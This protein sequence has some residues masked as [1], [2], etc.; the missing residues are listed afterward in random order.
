MIIDGIAASEAIDSSG[1]ILDV[2]G[3]DISSLENGDGLLNWEHRGEDAKGASANDNV[4]H[5]I[6]AKKIF[7][8]EDASDQR[9]RNYWNMVKLPYI[10]IKSRLYDGSGHPGAIALA[11]QIRDHVKNN[12]KILCRYSIEGSTLKKNGNRLERS[13]ARK[14]ACTVKPCNKSCV[15]GVVFDPQSDK[16]KDAS[17]SLIEG[18]L[19]RN[20]NGDIIKTFG[21]VTVAFDPIV[22]SKTL[23]AGNGS[24]PASSPL[25]REDVMKRMKGVVLATIRD[26]SKPF[27]KAEFRELL[28]SRLP[29]AD[30]SFLDRFADLAE[31]YQVKKSLAKAEPAKKPKAKKPPAVVTP[32]PAQETGPTEA[33]AATP[34][35]NLTIR[36]KEVAPNQHLSKSFFDEGTGVLHTPQGSF[37]MYI[38]SRDPDARGKESFDKIMNDPKVSAFHDKAMDNWS[39]VNGLL[40]AGQLP[41]EVVMHGTLFSQLSPNCL[42]AETE[43]LTKRGWVKGFDLTMDD[44]ILTKNPKTGMAEW[45]KPTDLRFFPDYEGPLVELK[46]RSF[47]AI[48]TPDH[49]WLVKSGRNNVQ[50]KTSVTINP[51]DLIHRTAKSRLDD[52]G[53]TPDVSHISSLYQHMAVVD[54]DGEWAAYTRKYNTKTMVT[55]SKERADAEQAFLTILGHASSITHD[56]TQFWVTK[57]RQKH[58]K[59]DKRHIRRYV[60]KVGMWCPVV[61]NTFFFMRRSGH[62][63]VTGNTPVPMQEIMFCLDQDTNLST[64]DNTIKKIKNFLPGDKVFGVSQNGEVITTE[65]VALHNHG[66]MEA[67][68]VEFS[69]GYRVVCSQNHKFLTTQ[70][71][72]P[73]SQIIASGLEIFSATKTKD[74]GLG[75]PLWSNISDRSAVQG[76]SERVSGMQG[77]TRHSPCRIGKAMACSES[78]EI[79]GI[80]STSP[81]CTENMERTESRIDD[82]GDS[83]MGSGKERRVSGAPKEGQ[84]SNAEMAKEASSHGPMAC[85]EINSGGQEVETGTSRGV[86][87]QLYPIVDSGPGM[88]RNPS[89]GIREYCKK[90]Y[91]RWSNFSFFSF[92]YRRGVKRATGLDIGT[93]SMWRYCQTGGFSP[94][95]HMD[96][97]GRILAFFFRFGKRIGCEKSAISPAPGHASKSRGFTEG[98]YH[99]NPSLDG[100]FLK[101]NQENEGRCHDLA[102]SDS[103][104][105]NTRNLVCRGVVRWRPVGQRQMYDLEVAHV[106]HNFLLPNGIITSNSHLVDS[107][108][109]KGID[110][111]SP[112]FE[113]EVGPD[114]LS[115]DKPDTLPVTGRSYFENLGPSVRIGKLVNGQ[116]QSSTKPYVSATTGKV[117]RTAGQVQSFMLANNKLKN[118]A[119]YH[120]LHQS[121]VDLVNRHKDDTRSAI[122]ELMLHK[123]NSQKHKAKRDRAISAGKPDIGP[124]NGPDVPGLAPKTARYMYGMLGGANSVVPDTH[125]VRHLFGLEKGADANTIEHLKSVLWEPNN[126]EVMNG[127]DRYYA[128]HHDAV[129]HMRNHPKYAGLFHNDESAVF[130]AFWKHWMSIVPHE[131]ARGMKTFGM[132]ADTDHTPYWEAVNPFLNVKKSEI[133]TTVPAQTAKQ[134]ADWVRQYGEMPALTLYYRYAIPKLLEQ[135][136]IR[137]GRG[138]M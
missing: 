13:I 90:V 42:D 120:G 114:W 60:G 101:Q 45:Q 71:M 55:K 16:K 74:D 129:K 36:G 118:M 135:A 49:R 62:V 133:D 85:H 58:A 5:I 15:S 107:M 115:R 32:P 2:E 76:A 134:H 78:R 84:S 50:E 22:L 87:G 97:S 80:T 105:S 93:D 91:R 75:Q 11:A 89:R 138:S 1:E 29:E 82:G 46:S 26:Y 63:C 132:N 72:V 10:Y 125:F 130:P 6:Y 43:A 17:S 112:K 122:Q 33:P 34:S 69:D 54:K 25:V 109:D 111:T 131:E 95:K 3:C 119:Q 103:P 53:F 44:W 30:D 104:I 14:V 124:Y 28:K 38:P 83:Q 68:E 27:V 57:L 9:Q 19:A 70:G 137:E 39:K 73:I 51:S 79:Q 12:E 41:P 136:R 99:S 56:G 4:G 127:I 59:L 81:C 126:S 128:K 35:T 52:N 92:L 65:V 121:L 113:G 64:C 98:R 116:Y 110:A 23:T 66:A 88:A 48:T 108:K 67:I 61:P 18:I 21:A 37:P 24:A 40:K 123:E 47:H 20:E 31:D 100:E 77:Y 117:G 8:E 102:Y 86:S 106:K 7:K 96:R 94:R